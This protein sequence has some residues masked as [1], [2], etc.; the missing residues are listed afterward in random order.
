MDYKII[1][2]SCTDLTP[3]QRADE[4]FR[5]IP[6]TIEV[7]Q[8]TIVDD[9]TFDQKSFLEKVA[10]SKDCP[11]SA[12]PSPEMYLEA[13]E[14]AEHI[15][16]VTL[17]SQLSGSYN[18]A[19]VA[20]K[21]CLEQHP[22]KK[23]EV[24]DSKSASVGQALIAAKIK[25]FADAGDTFESI[26]EKVNRY[27]D[28]MLT[29]FVLETLETLRKNGRL[30]N[31]TAFI[32]NTLD[33]KPIMSSTEEGAIMK[34]G[35]SRGMKRALLGMI[36][37]IAEN[38]KNPEEKILGIAHCNNYERALFTKKAILEKVPFKNIIITAT[39]GISSMYA[40]DGGII[41]CY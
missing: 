36:D 18:S 15:F 26:V 3:E 35:Q 1:G 25:E 34:I 23:I 14:E 20:K 9:D 16:V 38:V 4:S 41:V 40:S 11:K 24:F 22:E 32:C 37:H 29:L 17:S 12:C 6:L 2:D 7:A 21:L 19:M 39:R 13:Y 10:N 5:I 8:E 33:I 28:D 30:S 31:M 27:R